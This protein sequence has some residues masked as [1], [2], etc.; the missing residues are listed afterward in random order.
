MLFLPLIFILPV[1]LI[2]F[3]ANETIGNF[4]S[5][6][7]P[8]VKEYVWAIFLIGMALAYFEVFYGWA[9]VQ[10]RSVFGNFM[11]EIFCRVGQTILLVLLYFELITVEVFI[12][13]LVGIYLFRTLLMK[14]YAYSLRMPKLVIDFPENTRNILTY[15]LLIILG[16]SAVI[17]LL[18]IDKVMLNQFVEIENVAY[19]SVA[20][21]I[22]MVIAVPARSMHQIMY[23]LTAEVLNRRDRLALKNLYER[24][25][26][27]LYIVSGLLFVLILVNLDDLYELLPKAYR[28]GYIIFLWLGLAKLYDSILGN[29]NS[30]LYN[31]DY[32][33]AVL[34]LGVLLAILTVL[35]NLWLIPQYGLD[36][37]AIAS[38]SAFFIYNT[39]KLWYIKLKFDILPFTAETL[40]VTILLL[41]IGVVSYFLNFAF[42]PVINILLKS[43]IILALYVAFLYRFK[44]SEDVFSLL[45]RFTSK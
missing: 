11:K 32:Y 10:M 6:E 39:I 2:A 15:S 14:I 22:A 13:T 18:E 26:L 34:V 12:W 43:G 38:F 20:G 42:H 24:S 21:F 16:G 4:L 7:N 36:G 25:S 40:K 27:T 17:A 41:V 30:I 19:Y 8:I 29:S 3:F 28:D 1:A 35:F 23:P 44:I 9:R 33:R 5:K 37:A 45:K 31:S